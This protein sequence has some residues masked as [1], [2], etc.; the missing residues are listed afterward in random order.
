MLACGALAAPLSSPQVDSYN[1]RVGTETFAGMYH[2]T[3]NTLLVET[4]QA[5]TNLGSDA[6]KF[7]LGNDTSYQSGV[8]LGSNITNLLTLV[9]DQPSYHQV[10]DMPFRHFVMWAYPFANSDEWWGSGYNSTD[11]A[12]D[13]TEM[14]ALTQ[15]LL[16]NYNNSGKTFYLGHWEGDGYLEVSNWTVNPN[17][18]TVSGMIG[19]LNNR[20]LAVDNAKAATVYSNVFVYNYAECN[21]VQDAMNNG[22]NNNVRVIDDVVPYVTNLDYLSYSSYDSQNLTASG[23]YNTLNYMESMLPTNKA[24]VV[25]GERMWIGEYGWGYES[26]AAQEPLTRAYIQRLLGWNYNGRCLPFILFW[27]MY[28]NTNSGSGTNYSLI[29]YQDNKVPAWYLHNYFYNSAR[30]AAARWLET[31]GTLPS[32]VQ[33]TDLVTNMLDAVLPAPTNLVIVNQGAVLGSNSSASVSGQLTQGVYGDDEAKVWVYYGTQDAG[34]VAGSWKNSMLVGLNTNFNPTTFTASLANLTAPATYYYRFWASNASSQAWAPASSPFNTVNINPQTY[35]SQ[36]MISFAGYNRGET[37]T[38]FPV[39]VCLGTNCPGFSYRGF[40]S[41]SGGDLRFTD[42]TG[43]V[44]LYHEIDEWNTNGTS[45]VWVQVPAL[46]GPSNFIWAYWGNPGATNPPAGTTNGSVWTP[47]Y[48]VVYH[49]KENGFPYADSTGQHPALTGVAP[50]STTGV[51]GHAGSF[52]GTSDYLNAGTI[53]VGSGFTASAWVNMSALANN[54]VGIWCSK[55]GGYDSNGF[56]LYINYYNTTDQELRLETSDGSSGQDAETGPGA[57]SS[58][59]WHFVAAAV[60]VAGGTASMFVDGVNETAKNNVLTAFPTQ[61]VVELGRFTNGVYYFN[62]FIDEARIDA[63]VRDSNWVWASWMTVAS[64]SVLSAYSTVAR[65]APSL[66]IGSAGGGLLGTW[67]GSG[68]GFKLYTTTNLSLPISWSLAT[69]VPTY[70]NSQWQI[71]LPTN[72]AGPVFY[73]LQSQ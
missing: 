45:Y 6:I 21:R 58:N 14:Y 64:N 68:V 27:E 1:M 49:L 22:S 8:T 20:Q 43:L 40:A 17:P 56:G 46:S 42:S 33:F 34:T 32:D 62:G 18:A 73:R 61:L 72:S 28:S 35:G 51:V 41:P 13:Y 55:P 37:L 7:Y 39:L 57:V 65:S 15:Y 36:M 53:N 63:N 3:T 71:S 48:L 19:W 60:N 54:I 11:G 5:I 47:N 9:R 38:N 67:P 31:N 25:P 70:A 66:S 16:T 59:Q 69:N 44:P 24:S 23:L 2:F 52:N 50:S 30:L 4:A 10:L 29:D 12:K 26:Y